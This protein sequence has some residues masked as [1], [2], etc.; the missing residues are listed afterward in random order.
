MINP[1]VAEI[2]CQKLSARSDHNYRKVSLDLTGNFLR[3]LVIIYNNNYYSL[4]LREKY[5]T[6]HE[7]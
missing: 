4:T 2:L 7:W 5:G 1:Q 6:V 3:H